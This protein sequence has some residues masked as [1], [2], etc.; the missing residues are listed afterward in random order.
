M[1][2]DVEMSAVGGVKQGS[3]AL[4]VAVVDPEG[5]LLLVLFLAGPA[6]SARLLVLPHLEGHLPN[7]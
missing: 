1:L 6:V 4:M 3:E 7:E 2:D 5:E